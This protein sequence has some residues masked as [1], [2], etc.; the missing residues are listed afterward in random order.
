MGSQNEGARNIPPLLVQTW[1]TAIS[2]PDPL[3]ALGATRALGALLSTWEA[4]LASEAVASGATWEAIGSSVGVSRQAAWE[5]FHH[6]VDE[7]RRQVKSA[8]RTLKER[9]RQ[10]WKEFRDDVKHRALGERRTSR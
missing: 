8:A 6:D 9:Q 7:F 2:D 5:R 3:V 10:E 1:L 4:K